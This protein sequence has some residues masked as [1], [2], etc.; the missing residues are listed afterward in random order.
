MSIKQHRAFSELGSLLYVLAAIGIIISAMYGSYKQQ[1]ILDFNS[2]CY[3]LTHGFIGFL[4]EHSAPFSN[5]SA[6][7]M[8]EVRQNGGASSIRQTNSKTYV[9]W[10]IGIECNDKSPTFE[11]WQTPDEEKARYIS[12]TLAHS[13]GCKV[14]DSTI[15]PHDD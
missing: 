3:C 1:L 7:I 12:N 9:S 14:N 11:I 8:R 15:Y 5:V 13:F 2:R 10:G 4:K 6:V